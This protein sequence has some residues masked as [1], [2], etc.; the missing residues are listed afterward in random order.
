MKCAKLNKS[1]VHRSSHRH[2]GQRL[3]LKQRGPF[4]KFATFCPIGYTQVGTNVAPATH[5]GGRMGRAR[6]LLFWET[7]KTL[8]NSI[9]QSAGD[10]KL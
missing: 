5:L 4:E 3:G 8:A 2:Q 6:V 7:W 9:S 1:V 10:W